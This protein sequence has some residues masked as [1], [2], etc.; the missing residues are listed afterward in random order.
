MKADIEAA[1]KKYISDNCDSKGRQNYQSIDKETRDGI[2][3]LERRI[4]SGEL[5]SDKSRQLCVDTKENYIQ[6]MQ[7]HIVNDP[8][9]SM[10]V[11][12][13]TERVLNAHAIRATRILRTGENH[14]H[15]SRV[16][17]AVTNMSYHVHVLSGIKKTH[18]NISPVPVRPVCGADEANNQQLSQI[19]ADILM[20]TSEIVDQELKTTCRSTEEMMHG[21]TEVNKKKDEITN[22][23]LFSMDISGMFPALDIPECARI[24]AEMWFESGMEI[25]LDTEELGLYLAVTVDRARLEELGLAEFC[26]ARIKTRGAHPGITTK[27]ILSRD[28]KTK[29]LFHKPAKV[30]SKE[31]A[32]LM[33][34]VALQIMIKVCMQEHLYSFNGEL[35][36]QK[37][38]GAIGNVLTGALAT[39]FMI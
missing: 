39:I 18:K 3:S 12:D 17:Q 19:C 27:E 9:I 25:N 37:R 6:S 1:T 33:F 7:Q 22:L 38:G 23:V 15:E 4:T 26:H 24:A 13:E 28:S 5:V 34:K 14:G 2:V 11:R 20:A 35:R 10:E 16:R 29:S 8:I 36:K 31:Q 30:P 32:R 21:L